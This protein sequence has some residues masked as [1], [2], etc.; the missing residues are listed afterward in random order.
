MQL[1]TFTLAGLVSLV[2]DINVNMAVVVVRKFRDR[3]LA[4][5]REIF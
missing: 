5:S 3:G 4:V 2:L 1:L